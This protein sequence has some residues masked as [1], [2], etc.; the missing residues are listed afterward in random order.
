MHI[1]IERIHDTGNTVVSKHV[2]TT[3]DENKVHETAESFASQNLAQR[4]TH[5]EETSAQSLVANSSC[6]T[7]L[8]EFGMSEKEGITSTMGSSLL[9]DHCDEQVAD[10]QA[11]K[12]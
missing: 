1:Y 11:T 7:P 4:C 5:R 2:F 6:K 10:S 12:Y 9:L 8:T 3:L